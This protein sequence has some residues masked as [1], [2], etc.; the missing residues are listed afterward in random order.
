MS[1]KR[2]GRISPPLKKFL[3]TKSSSTAGEEVF[4]TKPSCMSRTP[5]P[6]KAFIFSKNADYKRYYT[7]IRHKSCQVV[8][9]AI[10]CI[11]I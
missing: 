10:C 8:R 9:C 11:M 1:K 5:L 7:K 2:R 4:Y 6:K 3:L